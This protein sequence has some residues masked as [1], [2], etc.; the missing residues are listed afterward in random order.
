MGWVLKAEKIKHGYTDEQRR[1]FQQRIL[2][3]DEST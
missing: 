3:K 2:H 1:V